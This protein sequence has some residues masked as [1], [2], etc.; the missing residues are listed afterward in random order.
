M[1]YVHIGSEIIPHHHCGAHEGSL[2]PCF[3]DPQDF[4]EVRHYRSRNALTPPPRDPKGSKVWDMLH[5]GLVQ[6]CESTDTLPV[7]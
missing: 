4:E 1:F 6:H 7:L 3:T 5:L 2:T